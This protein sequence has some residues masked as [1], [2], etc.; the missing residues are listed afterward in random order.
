MKNSSDPGPDGSGSGRTMTIDFGNRV[1]SVPAS[2]VA[3]AANASGDDV[4]ILLCLLDDPS[5]SP[6]EICSR[7]GISDPAAYSNAVAFWRG[8]GVISG[9]RSGRT[10]HAAK[11]TAEDIIVSVPTY[12]S[13]ELSRIVENDK[14][15][16]RM[17]DECTELLGRVFGETETA[18][19]ISAVEFYSLD[20]EYIVLICA[21]CAGIGKRSVGFVLSTVSSLCRSG[22]TTVPQLNEYL[23]GIEKSA[24]LET[25]IRQLVGMNMTRE[26]TSRER[27]F[28]SVWGDDYGYGI[29]VIRLAYEKTIDSIGEPVLAYM[30]AILGD[31]YGRGLRTEDDVKAFL[32][33]DKKNKN[34][35]KSF[36]TEEFFRAALTHSYGAGNAVPEVPKSGGPD[37]RNVGKTG[38]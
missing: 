9:G 38:R 31:W 11:K 28:I 10:G 37:T 13:T 4:K 20:P 26:L 14:A 24:K 34:P 36:D 12:S 17:I 30:N 29:E 2:A 35:E 25:Q 16:G 6:E 27:G 22:I 1:V 8:A 23:L 19:L 18:K 7:L 33:K 5:A 21:H 3:A 15:V 32:K